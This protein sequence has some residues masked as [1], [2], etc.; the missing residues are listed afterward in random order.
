MMYFMG[1]QALESSTYVWSVK[2]LLYTSLESL[3]L[4]VWLKGA[5][6]SFRENTGSRITTLALPIGFARYIKKFVLM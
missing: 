5:F 3:I 6:D 1:M 2:H 4:L